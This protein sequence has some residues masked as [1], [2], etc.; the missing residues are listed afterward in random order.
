MIE[1][2]QVLEFAGRN[3]HFNLALEECLLDWLP[4]AHD[5][6]L[7]LWQNDPAV[8][9]GRYQCL[10]QEVN[11][12]FARSHKIPVVRRI[13]GGGA[14]YHDKGNLN[15]SF[16]TSHPAPTQPDCWLTQICGAINKLGANVEIAGRNDLEIAGR[17]ISGTAQ[18]RRQGKLLLHGTLLYRA[19][20]EVL[21]KV[22]TPGKHKIASKGIAS[23]RSRVCSLADYLKPQIQIGDIK[24]ALAASLAVFDLPDSV[25]KNA[26]QL[27]ENKYGQYSWNFGA[28]PPFNFEKSKRFKWGE[29]CWRIYIKNGCIEVCDISGDF[30]SN[31]NIDDLQA[32]FL[33]LEFSVNA[34]DNILS[35]FNTDEMFLGSNKKEIEEFFKEGA[36]EFSF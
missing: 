5:D 34:I 29:I 2:M 24:N 3:P 6:L 4:D 32:K 22:L 26:R 17:K 9:I 15:F 36:Q 11:L 35:A 25:I 14:V 21:G 16:L 23:V 8:I 20:I 33:N 27:A 18:L 10:P 1:S 7:L 19:N 12:P 13:T 31:G 30:F 28:A